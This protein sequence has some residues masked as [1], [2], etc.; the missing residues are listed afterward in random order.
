MSS[1]DNLIYITGGRGFVGISLKNYLS[2]K[3]FIE[4]NRNNIIQIDKASTVIHL[5]GKAHDLKCV[6]SPEEYYI[7]NTELTKKVFDAFLAS[8]AKVFVTL[9]SV[10]AVA[11]DIEGELTEEFSPN[12][13]TH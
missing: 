7:V 12:P 3:A 11:D 10:K 5:A 9:S 13:K 4:Y 8:D 2:Q 1:L 6:L